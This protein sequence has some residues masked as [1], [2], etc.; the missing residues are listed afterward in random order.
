MKRVNWRV[1]IYPNHVIVDEQIVSIGSF[2]LK[3]F[4][5][6]KCDSHTGVRALGFLLETPV[7][8]FVY[9]SYLKD[10]YLYQ[11]FTMEG[12]I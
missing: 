9:S 8:I 2:P 4:D 11:L 12:D 7:N 10:T 3:H 5:R 1:E 6:V